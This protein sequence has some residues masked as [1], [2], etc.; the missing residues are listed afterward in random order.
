MLPLFVIVL[1][2]SPGASSFSVNPRAA[3]INPTAPNPASSSTP[4]S[5]ATPVDVV[6]VMDNVNYIISYDA[7][8]DRFK[9]A[10][11]LV[12]LMPGSGEIGI[13]GITSTPNPRNVLELQTLQTS[14][15]KALVNNTL[16]VNTFGPV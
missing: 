9:A 1:S 16:S 13:V 4:A 11:L 5:Q 8:G 10:Q 14:N 3:A 2:I 12:N 7:Q 6:I 15:D